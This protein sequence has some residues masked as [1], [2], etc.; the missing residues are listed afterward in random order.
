MGKWKILQIIPSHPGWKAFY[1]EAGESPL[2]CWGLI[3]DE[4][5]KDRF[6]VPMDCESSG[7]VSF[8]QQNSNFEEVFFAEGVNL[9]QD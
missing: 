4:E 6:V 7:D 2:V 9:S 8:C 1:K 5:T 3:E